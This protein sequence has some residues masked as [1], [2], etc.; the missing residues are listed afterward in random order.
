MNNLDT[1][2]S[3]YAKQLMVTAMR[4]LALAREM[5]TS[6]RSPYIKDVTARAER[7]HVEQHRLPLLWPQLGPPQG[8]INPFRQ[9]N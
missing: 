7:T 5:K 3:T 4:S 1:T 9:G 2:R 6:L 8:P